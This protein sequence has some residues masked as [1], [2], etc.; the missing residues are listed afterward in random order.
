METL[1][2]T[3]GVVCAGVLGTAGDLPVRFFDDFDY[4]SP[5]EMKKAGFF[6]DY[7][8]VFWAPD[9]ACE[10]EGSHCARFASSGKTGYMILEATRRANSS[11][12]KEA[13]SR[14]Q[15]T[16]HVGP[17]GTFAARVQFNAGGI[18]NP[19]TGETVH[20]LN[21]I[22][23]Q[24]FYGIRRDYGEDTYSEVDFEYLSPHGWYAGE[25]RF[26]PEG[27]WLNSWKKKWC[28]RENP[29][30]QQCPRPLQQQGLNLDGHWVTL[31][32]QVLPPDMNGHRPVRYFVAAPGFSE[33]NLYPNFDPA[34]GPGGPMRLEFSNWF[35]TD[36][37]NL[38]DF[39]RTYTMY[40]DW[41]FYTNDA[42]LLESHE[43]VD[44]VRA[45]VEGIQRAD[46]APTRIEENIV[47]DQQEIWRPAPTGTCLGE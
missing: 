35:S 17:E 30:S 43:V 5:A 10:D 7:A 46:L 36:A 20:D 47:C 18:V 16:F 21:D 40:V 11:G 27:L 32:F 15:S 19:A 4:A 2:F 33:D 22:N 3:V 29:P 38:H 23:D 44:D 6:I 42:R 25:G 45:A 8:Y 1:L 13:T 39:D 24:D 34:F 26:H 14:V 37:P 12:R 28:E 9:K 31:V 41:V